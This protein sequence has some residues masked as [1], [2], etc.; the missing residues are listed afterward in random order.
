MPEEWIQQL[1]AQPYYSIHVYD[2]YI[3]R[4]CSNLYPIMRPI[5]DL[6]SFCSVT[7]NLFGSQRAFRQPWIHHNICQ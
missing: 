2:Q 7:S 1:L 6:D 4:P 3:L 5:V